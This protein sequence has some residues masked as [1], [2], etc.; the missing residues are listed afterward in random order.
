MLGK[1]INGG[2]SVISEG[3][4][5]G[6]GKAGFI[7]PGLLSAS[8][9]TMCPSYCGKHEDSAKK[10]EALVGKKTMIQQELLALSSPDAFK[11]VS[12]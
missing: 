10:E 3:V 9:A 4:A 1:W 7:L 2:K 11:A 6:V 5:S 12:A 8:F